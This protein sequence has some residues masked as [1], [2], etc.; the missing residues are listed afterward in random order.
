MH[1]AYIELRLGLAHFFRTFPNSRVSAIEGMSKDDM[2]QALY[3][4][5]SPQHHRCLIEAA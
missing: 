1:L 2:K 5:A 4:I 3:F